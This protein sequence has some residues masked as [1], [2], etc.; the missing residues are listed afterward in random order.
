MTKVALG[1]GFHAKRKSA[2]EA[3]KFYCELNGLAMEAMKFYCELNGLA[4]EATFSVL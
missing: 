1:V 4:M 2:L 3:M